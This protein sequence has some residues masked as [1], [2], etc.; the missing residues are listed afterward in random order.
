MILLMEKSTEVCC[1]DLIRRASCTERE[2]IT[3]VIVVCAEK[4]LMCDSILMCLLSPM[5][6]DTTLAKDW[7]WISRSLQQ[8]SMSEVRA[9]PVLTVP[10][11]CVSVRP[12]VSAV[13]VFFFQAEDGIRD[14]SVTGVQT[15][16]LPI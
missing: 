6:C 11:V 14:W 1:S 13:A 7:T 5:S 9:A 12:M 8:C 15:C 16:A 4:L 2:E 3:A 10:H